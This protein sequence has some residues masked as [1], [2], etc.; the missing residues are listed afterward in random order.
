MNAEQTT[1]ED[2]TAVSRKKDHIE[3]AFQSRVGAASLDGRFWYEPMLAAHPEP[4]SWPPFPFMGH[5]LRSPMVLRAVDDYLAGI[6]LPADLIREIE[7][8]QLLKRAAL[9]A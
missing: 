1:P 5:Q 7:P 2:P 9:I 3:L 4:G 6:R 8:A